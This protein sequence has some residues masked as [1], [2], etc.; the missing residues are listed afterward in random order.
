MTSPQR[1]FAPGPQNAV[2]SITEVRVTPGSGSTALSIHQAGEEIT[3][4][5]GVGAWHDADVVAAAGGEQQS[6]ELAFDLVFVQ[7]PHRLRIVCAASEDLFAARWVTEPLHPLA[8]SD[9]RMPRG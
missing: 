7:T 1:T 5:A 6:G 3:V 8:L 9:M 2:P 4:H